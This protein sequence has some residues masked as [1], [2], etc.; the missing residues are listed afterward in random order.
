MRHRRRPHEREQRQNK[1]DR[2]RVIRH[3]SLFASLN[4]LLLLTSSYFPA[5]MGSFTFE[6]IGGSLRAPSSRRRSKSWEIFA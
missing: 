1:I 4:F 2:V 5:A 6:V 3:I